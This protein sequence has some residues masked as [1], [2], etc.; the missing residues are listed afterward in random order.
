MATLLRHAG[1]RVGHEAEGVEQ[2][3]RRRIHPRASFGCRIGTA[4]RIIG[5]GERIGMQII[6]PL[7]EIETQGLALAQEAVVGGKIGPRQRA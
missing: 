2:L 7:H 4:R 5:I 6:Q 3:P 1:G